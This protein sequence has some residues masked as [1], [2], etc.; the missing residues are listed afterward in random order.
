MSS[1]ESHQ[2]CVG[3]GGWLLCI[4]DIVVGRRRQGMQRHNGTRQWS[5]RMFQSQ[6][7]S[8]GIFGIIIVVVGRIMI[9]FDGIYGQGRGRCRHQVFISIQLRLQTRPDT[10]FGTPGA[11][12]PTRHTRMDGTGR[13]CRCCSRCSRGSSGGR[14]HYNDMVCVCVPFLGF[15]VENGCGSSSSS[16]LCSGLQLRN[17]LLG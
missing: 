15:G 4:V 16:S 11:I 3:A 1:T 14:R 10:K 5:K 7:L 6:L 12:H 13:G 2:Q 9:L 17:T 8:F